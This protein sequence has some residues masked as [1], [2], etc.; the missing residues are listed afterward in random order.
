MM[1]KR[2][3]LS[4]AA[5]LALSACAST[6]HV[7]GAPSPSMTFENFSPMTLNVQAI[8]VTQAS[9]ASD[10]KD[11]SVQF[12]IPPEQA[13]RQYA[14]RRFSATGMGNGQFTLQIQDSRVHFRQ[15]QED[16]KVLS[17]S[18]IGQE[19]EY[20][21]F[22][23]VMVTPLPDG[24]QGHAS[25]VLTMERTL[26]MPSSVTLADREMRQIKF[27]EKMIADLDTSIQKVL[28]SVPAIRQ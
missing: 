24:A 25:T 11:I 10:P 20:R 28:D 8:Q 12:V 21:V 4:A 9:M 14:D 2:F 6:A 17:W 13:V 1:N 27:M 22:L 19:D 16:S 26:V 5:I 18:G 23:R 7:D 15:I 3:F